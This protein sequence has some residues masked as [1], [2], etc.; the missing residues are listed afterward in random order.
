MQF[1]LW[2]VCALWGVQGLQLSEEPPPSQSLVPWGHGTDLGAKSGGNVTGDGVITPI[3]GTQSSGK[4]VKHNSDKPDKGTETFVLP[5]SSNTTDSNT[6]DR[7]QSSSNTHQCLDWQPEL[8]EDD[9]KPQVYF[10]DLGVE[11][12]QTTLTALGEGPRK[13]CQ[14]NTEYAI[15]GVPKEDRLVECMAR[16]RKIHKILS[17]VQQEA[18]K[19]NMSLFNEGKIIMVE[20][21]PAFSPVLKKITDAYP[22]RAQSFGKAITGYDD[23]ELNIPFSVNN[24]STDPEFVYQAVDKDTPVVHVKGL[25]LMQLLTKTVRPKD[26]VIVKMN[27]AGSEYEVLPCLV[28][29]SSVNLIDMFLLARHDWMPIAKKTGHKEQLDRA[30]KTMQDKH[31]QVLQNWP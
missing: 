6:T 8:K 10:F 1:V 21:S 16:T 30:V 3:N 15:T 29:S 20:P 7:A 22:H 5:S 23:S 2:M 31:I 25:N 27:V 14:Y 12:G 17:H 9:G 11:T 13:A 19:V 28:A 18:A 26:F 24:K 4:Q